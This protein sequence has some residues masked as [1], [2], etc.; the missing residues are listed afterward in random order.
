MGAASFQKD[1][2]KI[3]WLYHDSESLAGAPYIAT[4]SDGSVRSGT[5]DGSGKA[6][7]TGL[8]AGTVSAD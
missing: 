7:I 1:Q 2:I 6:L 4:L 8:N 5:L 3:E